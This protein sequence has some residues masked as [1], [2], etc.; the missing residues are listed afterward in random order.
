MVGVAHQ[1][2][3]RIAHLR[4]VKGTDGA[5]HTDGDARVGIDE[6]GRER[7]RQ[8]RGLF[9]GGVVV[10]DKVDGVLIDIG[11]ELLRDGGELGLRVTGGGPL[12]IAGIRLAEVPLGIH[13][14]V[15][16]RLIPHGE[17]HHCI[18]DR[19]IAVRVQAHGGAH[20]VGRLGP[21]AGEQPHL[22]HRIEQLAVRGLK[23]VD[24][25]DRAGEDNA[26]R[27]GHVV[28]LERLRDLLLH[29]GARAEDVGIG[30][31]LLLCGARVLFFSCHVSNSLLN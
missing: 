19:S 21:A 1:G 10:V 26:H 4:Q 22:I 16:Q 17:A 8:E 20:D 13:I 2:D 23:A 11:E 29:D 7:H 27:V 12:H 9:H 15:E 24:L 25:R 6:D 14:G 5:R 18:I 28:D 31:C 3:G 30:V